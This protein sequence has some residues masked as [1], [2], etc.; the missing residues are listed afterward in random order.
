MTKHKG[1]DEEAEWRIIYVPENDPDRRL[2]KQLPPRGGALSSKFAPV[3][4]GRVLSVAFLTAHALKILVIASLLRPFHCGQ[5][6]VSSTF[7]GVER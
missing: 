7:F 3:S 5:L 1:F 2:V 4:G 6:P